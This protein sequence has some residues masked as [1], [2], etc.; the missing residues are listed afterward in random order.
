MSFVGLFEDCQI[1]HIR[2]FH[3]FLSRNVSLMPKCS[4]RV[5]HIMSQFNHSFCKNYSICLFGVGK[6]YQNI[7]GT[8]HCMELI[9]CSPSPTAHLRRCLPTKKRGYP[10]YPYRSALAKKSNLDGSTSLQ[11]RIIFHSIKV[12]FKK[13]ILVWKNGFA[14]KR[15]LHPFF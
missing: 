13:F 1:S 7:F 5:F 10:L 2:Y 14:P 12:V 9:G 6:L 3:L 4:F 15:Y 11:E 8:C